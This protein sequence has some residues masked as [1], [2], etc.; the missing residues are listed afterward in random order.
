MA[1]LSKEDWLEEGF[2]LLSEFAQDKLRIAY[3]CAHFYYIS[4]TMTVHCYRR[5]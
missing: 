3:L 2:R 4:P 5:F 1:R